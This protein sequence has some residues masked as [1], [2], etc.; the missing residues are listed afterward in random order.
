MD[1]PELISYSKDALAFLKLLLDTVLLLLSKCALCI[2]H[3]RKIWSLFL[4]KAYL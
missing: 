1:M 3:A 2:A 4:K